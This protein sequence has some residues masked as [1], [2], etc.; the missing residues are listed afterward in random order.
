[1][2]RFVTS[3]CPDFPDRCKEKCFFF[4]E[5]EFSYSNLYDVA[6]SSAITIREELEDIFFSTDDTK[7]TN[8]PK[9]RSVFIVSFAQQWNLKSCG[10]VC[11]CPLDDPASTLVNSST[12]SNE[13]TP[14]IKKYSINTNLI[15]F[16][17]VSLVVQIATPLGFGGS[18]NPAL[19]SIITTGGNEVKNIFVDIPYNCQNFS[20]V[21]SKVKGSNTLQ[22]SSS[23]LPSINFSLINS[24]MYLLGILGRDFISEIVENQSTVHML[25]NL[26]S[27]LNALCSNG[28]LCSV[29][30]LSILESKLFFILKGAI[31]KIPSRM[32][33]KKDVGVPL[34][35]GWI[36]ANQV[37]LALNEFFGPEIPPPNNKN[38]EYDTI[39]N[40]KTSATQL[41]YN[42]N[43]FF[44]TAVIVAQSKQPKCCD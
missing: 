37:S 30:L 17:R 33:C 15:G 12:V 18:Q 7:T 43:T 10:K 19:G 44:G 5:L 6:N 29:A 41:A 4:N 28:G 26:E 23:C 9:N 16:V 38:F 36:E 2:S 31:G 11:V 42:S 24:P 40:G 35:T 39:N 14:S 27:M 22:I 1:M 20:G 34:W 8:S 3:Q 32:S 21:M 13:F 25:S